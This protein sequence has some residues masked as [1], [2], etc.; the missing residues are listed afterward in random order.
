MP[1]PHTPRRAVLALAAAL[2]LSGCGGGSSTDTTSSAGT[3]KLKIGVIPI[4]DVAPIYL[5][6][7]QGFFSAEGLDVTL[8]TA[9]G[10]AAIVPGVVSGQYQFGF[11]NTTSL[12]LASSQGLPL[13]AV[14][15]GVASTGVEGK[16]F[17]AVIV[18]ADS[19]IKT[20]K[21][22]AGKRVAVNTLKNI[23]TTTINNVV[24][25]AG[26]D[27]STIT[28]VELAFPDIG[29]AIA[30]GDV[31]AGQV[32]EP[33]LTIGTGQGNRQVVSNYAGTDA[34]LTVGM[35]FTSQQYASQNPKV[36]AGFTAAMKKSM[37]YAA[38]HPDDVRAILSTYTKIDPT[39]QQNLT[40]PKW[41]TAVDRDAVQLLGDLAKKD[42]L[43]TKPLTLDTLLP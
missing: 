15:A 19:P 16:D 18:K 8:E 33:F 9:Q 37:E 14:A 27:P 43:I 12:L 4:V 36:V 35:Y 26:G 10:G 21:D 2:V 34:D 7:K 24:Q 25:K 6:I 29:A 42:G 32:V 23:N 3:T 31:D 38:A 5:G 30:K 39:V 11:S 13:K 40:L 22:L 28:Y 20:A 17:G 1:R 41:P